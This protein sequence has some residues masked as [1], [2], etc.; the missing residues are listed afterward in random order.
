M[1]RYL[2]SSV[3]AFA[4]TAM[5]INGIA[6][7]TVS[8]TAAP[9]FSKSNNAS[10]S[11]TSNPNRGRDNNNR[12]GNGRGGETI[13][14]GASN[15]A[16]TNDVV[17]AYTSENTNVE[18]IELYKV[19]VVASAEAKAALEWFEINCV[20]PSEETIIEQC[21][22]LLLAASTEAGKPLKYA[23]YLEILRADAMS[24][25]KLEDKAL[26]LAA[27]NETDADFIDALWDL[28]EPE[29]FE[30]AD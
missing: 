27:N 1:N 19:A 25:N 12:G 6:V 23:D 7:A 24:L 14:D 9:A 20:D 21:E 11:S 8:L 15:A 22:T 13:S 17:L 5:A 26:E 10:S 2:H 30:A 3:I 16:H 4:I 28:L 29:D 18:M